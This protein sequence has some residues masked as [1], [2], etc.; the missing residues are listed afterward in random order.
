[1]IDKAFSNRVF[2]MLIIPGIIPFLGLA[3]ISIANKINEH[4]CYKNVLR[5]HSTPH[6]EKTLNRATYIC[7]G[8]TSS[9]PGDCYENI[10]YSFTS[11]PNE[12]TLDRVASLCTAKNLINAR[13]LDHH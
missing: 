12:E 5:N 2:A 11:L 7:K 10:L 1:M 4:E 6:D 3:E 8:A 13:Y 9:V